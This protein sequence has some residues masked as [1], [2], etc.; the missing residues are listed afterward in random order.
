MINDLLTS[1]SA[2][3]SPIVERMRD[4]QVITKPSGWAK[5]S[6]PGRFTPI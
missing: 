2:K 3:G 6:E 4:D 1:T 5:R